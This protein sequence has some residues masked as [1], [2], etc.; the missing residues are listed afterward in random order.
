MTCPRHIR[1]DITIHLISTCIAGL[2][3]YLFTASLFYLEIFILGGVLVDLDHLLDYFC[4]S[5]GSFSLAD[6]I[7]VRHLKAGKVYL[8]LHSWEL[9]LLLLLAAPLVKSSVMFLLGLGLTL[10]LLID[11]AQRKNK[12]FYF[13]FYR[14]S[15]DFNA[16]S[17]LEGEKE[18]LALAIEG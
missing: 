6:F 3:I 11:Q 17:L 14:F 8:F 13:L 9:D 12:L 4:Y 10:H 2:A 15:K 16:F 1:I 5:R 18:K 7:N